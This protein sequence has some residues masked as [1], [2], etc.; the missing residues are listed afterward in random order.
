[1]PL[2][3]EGIQYI[4]LHFELNKMIGSLLIDQDLFNIFFVHCFLMIQ[5][6]S[7]LLSFFFHY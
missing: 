6:D 5:M 1:M 4:D 3:L 7:I 2:V